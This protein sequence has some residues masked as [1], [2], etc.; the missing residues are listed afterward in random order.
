M[1]S[2]LIYALIVIFFAY[3]VKG[4]SGFGP[5]LIVI[6]SLTLLF[7]PI[8][9]ITSSTLF[10]V[11]AG[12]ILLILVIKKVDWKLVVPVTLLLF[13]GTFIGVLF[14]KQ[15]PV[16]L[17]KTFIAVV[18]FFF[19]LILITDS[20]KLF[21]FAK[22]A[23]KKFVYTVAGISGIVGGITGISGPLLV[24]VMK[25]KFKK[26]YFR[27]QLIAIFAFGAFWRLFL[28]YQGGIIPELDITFLVSAIIAVLIGLMVGNLLQYNVKEKV[29]NRVIALLLIIPAANIVI[30]VIKN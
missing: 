9:A 22:N 8:L 28:Y 17:L 3:F 5:A 2:T 29:F 20:E 10:D 26:E 13:A 1:D 23:N 24:V 16:E 27:N 18:L 7:N 21:S 15:M 19:I 25:L 4:F 11:I 12:L 14:I 6:P 30:D